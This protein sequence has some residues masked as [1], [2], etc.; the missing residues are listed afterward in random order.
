MKKLTNS[1]FLEK[2]YVYSDLYEYNN[3]NYI[4]MRTKI[5]VTCKI[6]GDFS[7]LPYNHIVDNQ[8]CKKC[9]DKHK[10]TNISDDRLIIMKN[11]HSNKYVYTDLSINNGM[12]KIICNIHGEFVQSIHNHQKGHGCYECSLDDRRVIKYRVCT[13]CNSSKELFN[14]K[15]GYRKCNDCLELKVEHKVCRICNIDKDI[16]EY[17]M[18]ENKCYRNECKLCY[19]ILHNNSSKNYRQ[20]NKIVLREKNRIYHKKRLE[21][22]ILYRLKVSTRNLIRKSLTKRGYTKTSRTYEILGC[23]YIEFKSHIEK[24]FS[25]GMNW[26]NRKFWHIDHIIPLDFALDENELLQLNHFTNL[27]PLWEFE[28]L[29]KSNHIIDST[30][31]YYDIL[32]NR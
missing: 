7:I 29:S 3:T 28:N 8:G 22:D 31:L 32:E 2:C 12:I 16:N 30:D 5:L 20:K 24:L 18:R 21:T 25:N 14:F 6:H 23:S 19:E 26:D 15:R 4:N 11:I 9:A 17:L 13:Y 27:Q 1:E 10:L